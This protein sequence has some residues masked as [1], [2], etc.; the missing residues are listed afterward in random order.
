MIIY[1]KIMQKIP[2]SRPHTGSNKGQISLN[3]EYFIFIDQ[4]CCK[5]QKVDILC[6]S[7]SKVKEGIVWPDRSYPKNTILA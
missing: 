4:I 3:T 7:R 2:G 5:M 6:R 1:G